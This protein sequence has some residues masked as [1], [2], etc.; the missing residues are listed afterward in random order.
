M[1]IQK[2]C[3]S[4]NAFSEACFREG[5]VAGI[6]SNLGGGGGGGGDAVRDDPPPN[7]VKQPWVGEW[8][9]QIHEG[10]GSQKWR[11]LVQVSKVDR[12]RENDTRW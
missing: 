8:S 3:V 10:T 9:P 11:M 2:K 4:K 5:L 6:R 7:R 1:E 12:P